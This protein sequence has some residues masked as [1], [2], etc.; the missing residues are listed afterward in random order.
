MNK[1]IISTPSTVRTTG[2]GR[3]SVSPTFLQLSVNVKGLPRGIHTPFLVVLFTNGQW[4]QI[5]VLILG[6][7]DRSCG[8]PAELVVL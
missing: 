6:V 4:K 8:E 2:T 5:A 3:C 1:N 7:C